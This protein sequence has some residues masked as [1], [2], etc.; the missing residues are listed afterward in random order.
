VL[1]VSIVASIRAEKRDHD[2]DQPP[3]KL[4]TVDATRNP[5]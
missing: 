3:G 5:D 2:T 1:T 4:D